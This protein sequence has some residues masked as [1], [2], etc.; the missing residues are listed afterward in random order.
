MRR[1]LVTVVVLTVLATRRWRWVGWPG[2]GG[3]FQQR[4][5]GPIS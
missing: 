5:T 3:D 2:H 4:P 1:F